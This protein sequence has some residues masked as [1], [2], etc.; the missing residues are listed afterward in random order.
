ATGVVGPGGP[1]AQ[2]GR[3]LGRPLSRC[4]LAPSRRRGLDCEADEAAGAGRV[5]PARRRGCGPGPPAG[6]CPGGGEGPV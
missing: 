5:V 1:E 6:L 2:T 3:R 4:D